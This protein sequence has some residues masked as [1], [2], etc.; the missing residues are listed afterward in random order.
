MLD[1][2]GEEVASG[3]IIRSGVFLGLVEW[4]ATENGTMEFSVRWHKSDGT[5]ISGQ[6]LSDV[7]I[8][9]GQ[10]TIIGNIRETPELLRK[11]EG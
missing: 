3:D 10:V 1:A 2:N 6:R 11:K 7:W 5:P 9:N 4:K 8:G